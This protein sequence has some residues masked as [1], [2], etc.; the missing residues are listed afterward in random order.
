[1]KKWGYPALGWF[2]F[3]LL[4]P[5]CLILLT[6]FLKRGAYG[7]V[8]F[9]F[10]TESYER[11]FSLIYANIFWQSLKLS[12]WTTGICFVLA[13]PIAWV[14]A[15]ARSSQRMF[16]LFLIS[17]PFLMNLIIRIFALR[18]MAGFDG[19]V[20][21]LLQWM[22]IAHDPY[23]FSQNQILVIYG[24]VTSY[25]PFMIFPLYAALEK[26]DFSLLEA[27]SDLG[28][29]SRTALFKVLIPNTRKAI[30]N[31]SL[32]VFVP[33]FGEFVIPDLLGGAKN[34]LIGNLITEQFLK[35]RDW[36]F[37]SALSVVLMLILLVMSL[38]IK[39]VL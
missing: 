33:T 22:G 27:C 32:L 5:L 30:A 12:M 13:Y 28:G 10:S 9:E 19:P 14:M 31:G 7:G 1:M 23:A 15:T 3:F 24:M 20:V 18:L 26:F 36:P 16:F 17:L 39:R 37:G 4:G 29:S 6:S 11:I 21:Q 25:L 2:S 38:V 35:A 34:M 8:D